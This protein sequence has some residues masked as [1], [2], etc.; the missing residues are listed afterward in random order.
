MSTQNKD[1]YYCPKCHLRYFALPKDGKCNGSYVEGVCKTE[2]KTLL[3]CAVCGSK[4]EDRGSTNLFT[5]AIC[6]N[7]LDKSIQKEQEMEAEQQMIE[8]EFNQRMEEEQAKAQ[9][10]AE[11]E[12][13]AQDEQNEQDEEMY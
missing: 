4:F 13:I 11:Q 12:Q 3:T 6:T 10:E 9:F 8:A 2:L 7:C 5:N 1:K